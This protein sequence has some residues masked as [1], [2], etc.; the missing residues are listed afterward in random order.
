MLWPMNSLEPIHKAT[1]RPKVS[2]ASHNALP[3]NRA[4]AASCWSPEA[5]GSDVNDRNEPKA[6]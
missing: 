2:R 5:M 1:A 6:D 4:D 3:A